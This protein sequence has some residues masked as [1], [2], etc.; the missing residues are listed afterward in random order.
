MQ[1]IL[2]RMFKQTG[3]ENA[4][5]PLFIPKS[6]FSKEA[7]HVEGFAK[8][9]RRSDALPAEKRSRRQGAW[10]SIPTPG[11]KRS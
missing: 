10:W 5:F 2:D 11:S 4:Y 9:V 1:A 7:H 8:G 6:F 3:H